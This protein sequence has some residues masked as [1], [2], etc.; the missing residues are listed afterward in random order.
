MFLT[1][2]RRRLPGSSRSCSL[3][4]FAPIDSQPAALTREQ[5]TY[6]H[7]KTKLAKKATKIKETKEEEAKTEHR[8]V[9]APAQ[10]VKFMRPTRSATTHT[11]T[12]QAEVAVTVAAASTTTTTT[13]YASP[14]PVEV[15]VASRR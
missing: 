13:E 11:T 4:L 3:S 6:I 12:T 2:R 7:K 9:A 5:H 1:V 10:S 8:F 14:S 15:L